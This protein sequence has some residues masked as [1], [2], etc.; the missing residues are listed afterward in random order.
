[1]LYAGAGCL[2]AKNGIFP[3]P[4]VREFEDSDCLAQVGHTVEDKGL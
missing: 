2:T 3:A 1:M 4:A